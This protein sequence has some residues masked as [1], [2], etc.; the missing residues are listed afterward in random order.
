MVVSTCRLKRAGSTLRHAAYRPK[1]SAFAPSSDRLCVDCLVFNGWPDAL[2]GQE[3]FRDLTENARLPQLFL[4]SFSILVVRLGQ[5]NSEIVGKRHDLILFGRAQKIVR[6]LG[7]EGC[8]QSMRI[9]FFGCHGSTLL[10]C[11][12]RHYVLYIYNRAVRHPSPTFSTRRQNALL[13]GLNRPRRP[14]NKGRGV[15]KCL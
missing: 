9:E 13:F 8:Q 1:R 3:A 10:A 14:F 2:E 11:A 7:T 6:L 4:E 5:K 15:S 12:D